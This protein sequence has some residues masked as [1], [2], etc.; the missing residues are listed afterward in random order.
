MNLK[1]TL[2]DVWLVHSAGGRRRGLTVAL[3]DIYEY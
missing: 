2:D 3:A 1:L